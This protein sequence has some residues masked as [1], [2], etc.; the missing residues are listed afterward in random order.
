MKITHREKKKREV[1]RKKGLKMREAVLFI[2]LLE[3]K[4]EG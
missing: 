4:E 3:E 1:I 2:G